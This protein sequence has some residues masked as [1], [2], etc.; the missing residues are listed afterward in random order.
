MPA[1][2]I[3]RSSSPPPTGAGIDVVERRSFADHHRY[4]GEE[5]GDLIMQ[6]ERGGLSLLTTEKDRARMAGDPLL[7]ALAVKVARVC[8]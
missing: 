5:A 1:S 8:R 2:A 6:A 3:R 4:S 7:A